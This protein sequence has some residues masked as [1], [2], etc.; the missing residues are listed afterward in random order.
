MPS[1]TWLDTEKLGGLGYSKPLPM[2]KNPLHTLRKGL[3]K[4]KDSVEARRDNL[5][6][7]LN[8][9]ERI[10]DEDEEWLDNAGNLV[11][12]EAIVDLL[13]RASDYQTGFAQLTLQQKSLVKK[14]K[15]LSGD[16]HEA[17]LPPAIKRKRKSKCHGP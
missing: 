13:E 6:A 16:I 14:L 4:L 17:V 7:C 15:E 2:S 5:L 11:D 1:A 9:K 12:E 8:R 3:A 10:S